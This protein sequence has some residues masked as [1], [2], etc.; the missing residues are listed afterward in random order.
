MEI[1]RDVLGAEKHAS[2]SLGA[3]QSLVFIFVCL[4]VAVGNETRNL[5]LSN[6]V[7]PLWQGDLVG[8]HNLGNT[9]LSRFERLAFLISSVVCSSAIASVVQRKVTSNRVVAEIDRGR[10][11]ALLPSTPEPS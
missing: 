5:N 7:W 8:K 10:S 2:R 9:L 1:R 11:N 4:I 6:V 3:V